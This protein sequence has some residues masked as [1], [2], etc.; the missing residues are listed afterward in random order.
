MDQWIL[1]GPYFF[2]G[3]PLSKTPKA[4]CNTH[5]DYD[6]LDLADLP[7]EY[8][9]RS[10]YLP[11]CGIEE[12]PRRISRVTWSEPSE[13]GPLLPKRVTEYYRFVNREMIGP[14]S[15]R[16]L[17]CGILPKGVAHINTCLSTS[18][19]NDRDMLDYY[20]MCLSVPV[21]YRV[22]N[23]GMGHANT[24]LINQLP[25]LDNG[26]YRSALHVRAL[27]LNSLTTAY[28]DLWRSCFQPRPL[29]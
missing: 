3:N 23:T 17:I 4:Q 8:L 20:A 12:Y 9:P 18:F 15:E 26:L 16:T 2:V 21:D 11:D 1:S 24:T 10:N 27:A 22:K 13:I 7:D 5:L 6:V 29:G 28:A 19:M 14:S 25:V